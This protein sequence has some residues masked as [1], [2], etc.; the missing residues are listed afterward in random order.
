MKTL[1]LEYP[2]KLD[3]QVKTLVNSG[4]A[5]SAEQL[6]LDALKRYLET[7]RLE[8]LER[9]LRSDIEWGISGND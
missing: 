1:T 8:V 7:H 5:Q 6:V 4:W 2:D 9:Q 3:E